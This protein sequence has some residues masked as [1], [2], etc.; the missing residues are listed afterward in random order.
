MKFENA[1]GP[2]GCTTEFYKA[3]WDVLGE[4]FMDAIEFFFK[5]DFI[6]Y[7]VNATTI[8]LI[9]KV[10]NPIKTNDFRPVSCCNVTYKVISKVLASRLKPYFPAYLRKTNQPL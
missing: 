8:S 1:I 2:N 7:P 5:N 10:D 6:Y 3:N 9:P 4:E